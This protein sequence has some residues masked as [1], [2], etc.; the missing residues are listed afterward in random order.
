MSDRG[1]LA[2]LQDLSVRIG[3]AAPLP[4]ADVPLPARARQ[5]ILCAAS[6][7][8]QTDPVR[9]RQSTC[10]LK[11]LWKRS[12][13]TSGNDCSW[14]KGDRFDPASVHGHGR[15]RQTS[16]LAQEGRFALVRLHQMERAACR[17]SKHQ[18]R[19]S[20]ATSEID[21]RADAVAQQRRKLQ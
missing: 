12:E 2:E 6:L 16:G 8:K 10:V 21:D 9:H 3:S 19:E 7:E 14:W 5:L 15:L 1:D 17:N 13:S 11:K 4:D 20:R 18:A